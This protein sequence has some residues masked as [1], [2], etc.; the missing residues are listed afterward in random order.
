MLQDGLAAGTVDRETQP[1]CELDGPHHA[2]RIFAE[3]DVGV[4]DASQQTLLKI[5]QAA[6]KIDHG[7]RLDI[8]EEPV[9]REIAAFGIFLRRAEGVV[10]GLVQTV[11][12]L[13]RIGLAPEGAGLDHLASEDDVRQ[14][15]TSADQETITEQA[16]DFIRPRIRPDV[17][18]LGLTTE[19]QVAHTAGD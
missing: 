12:I 3:A 9:H 18:I 1:R 6:H 13:H 8:V 17:K 4:A 15:K 5:L 11:F 14:P 16:A 19:Q 2:Y 7:K 10:F